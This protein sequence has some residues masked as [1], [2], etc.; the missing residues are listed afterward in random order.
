MAMFLVDNILLAPFNSLIWVFKEIHESAQQEIDGEADSVTHALSALYMQL[1][2]GD[3]T[4]EQ[5]AAEEKVLLDRL[6][7][8][9]E[10]EEGELDTT[11]SMD[12]SEDD[13]Q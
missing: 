11:E 12:E 6:D 7:E 9:W 10:R 8:I 3:I 5:F 13:Q 4:D 2:T 1:D